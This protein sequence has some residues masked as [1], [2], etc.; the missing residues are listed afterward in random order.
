MTSEKKEFDEKELKKEIES[1]K[2]RSNENR[3][4][5]RYHFND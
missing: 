3:R 2:T 5:D 4:Y 1:V